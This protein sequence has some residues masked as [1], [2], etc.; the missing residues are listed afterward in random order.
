MHATSL[1][2]TSE[3][4]ALIDRALA[5]DVGA[6]DVTTESLVPEDLSA[7]AL[8]ISKEAGVLAGVDV[9]LA[10]FSRVDPELEVTALL[11]DGARLG[12]G[13]GDV[14][15]EIEGRAASIL[16][17]ERTAL[18][19]AQRL[20]GVS[21]ETSR[22]V[23]A[24][25]GLDVRILDTRKT[26]PG[27][28]LLEKYAVR[29]GGGHNH[30]RGL[31]DGVLIKDN[32]IHALE[33]LGVGLSQ[34][35]ERAGAAVSHTLRIEIEVEDLGQLREALSAGADAILLDNMTLEDM[36]AAVELARGKALLEASGGI[37]LDNVR[38]VAATGVDLISVGALTH[39]VRSLDLGL[40][41]V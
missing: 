22:Y 33:G 34:V 7:K 11:K 19:F 40:D 18:N 26:T 13:E 5:E 24:V 1:R 14:V 21:T 32:H 10:V 15:A 29:I 12:G 41:M 35:I 20:S 6:G 30:R 37:T 36:A 27:L 17:A 4:L 23:D 38:E 16:T 8:L 9:A 28:R 31:D 25:D 3:T 39:S 2:I